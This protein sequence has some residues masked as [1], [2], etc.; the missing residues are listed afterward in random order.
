MRGTT[1]MTMGACIG[2]RETLAANRPGATN[3]DHYSLNQYAGKNFF[4]DENYRAA[5]ERL[6]GGYQMSIDFI[7]WM[8]EYCDNE[9]EQ[10][11]SFIDFAEKWIARIKQQSSLVSY[12][13][14]KRAQLD[15]V[16]IPKHLAQLK[17]SNCNEIQ[18]VI[19]KYRNYV[20]EIYINERFRPG[21]KHRRTNE[22]KKL[23]KTAHA[24]LREVA[25]Q[26]A[27]LRTSEKKAREALRTA[28]SACE[29][30]Q[31]D[32]S[33]TEKQLARANEVQN[34]KRAILE[35]IEEKLVD[36][37]AT[38][39]VAQKTYRKK[40][41]EI[42]K[43]CQ[44]VEEE[45]LDHIRE[46]LLDFIQVMYTPKYS[47]ELNQIFDGLTT[48]ITTQQNSFDDLLFWA[49]AYGIENKLT[50]SLPLTPNDDDHDSDS[51][52]ESR[53]NKKLTDHETD[54]NDRRQSIIEHEADDEEASAPIN[55]TTSVKTKVKRTKSITPID[56][57]NTHTTEPSTI[58]NTVL[59]QV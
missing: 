54:K 25:D 22:F 18:K 23:F 7:D 29:I 28:E 51:I 33:T 12:H 14:T 47:S 40:A 57:K 37:K 55:T 35:D 43:Q 15:V 41:T 59:N 13:T 20:N 19:D 9:R 10:A 42:F 52:I 36:T 30:I 45:R 5:L 11:R 31:L 2:F 26:L 17:E 39:R 27:T 32:P 50:K 58:N 56:K 3:N 6:D 49:K 34:K 21:R 44:T 46:T 8:Q 4:E 1:P 16:R 38:Y 48:K 53:T 24:S